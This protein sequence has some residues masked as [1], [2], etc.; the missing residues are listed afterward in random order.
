MSVSL[1]QNESEKERKD[2][3]L[4][5]TESAKKTAAFTLKTPVGPIQLSEFD[6][7]LLDL[8]NQVEAPAEGTVITKDL[9]CFKNGV[10]RR[11]YACM[12]MKYDVDDV[13]VITGRLKF[14]KERGFIVQHEADKAIFP[15]WVPTKKLHDLLGKLKAAAKADPKLY[16]I[17]MDISSFDKEIDEETASQN[18]RYKVSRKKAGLGDVSVDSIEIG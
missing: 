1:R 4:K 2:M 17:S 7:D 6:V 18:G 10:P 14:Y 16:S 9:S 15:A 13:K 12:G 3:S 8:V 11:L 5:N